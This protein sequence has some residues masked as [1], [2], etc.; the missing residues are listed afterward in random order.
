MTR[1]K[2]HG[3]RPNR[4][5][6]AG[7]RDRRQST[8]SPQPFP[9]PRRARQAE[10]GAS[11][12]CGLPLVQPP[13]RFLPPRRAWDT[14]ETADASPSGSGRGSAFSRGALSAVSTEPTGEFCEAKWL[15]W[16][17]RKSSERAVPRAAAVDKKPVSHCPAGKSGISVQA[18][19]YLGH[20]GFSAPRAGKSGEQQLRRGHRVVVWG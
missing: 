4:T 16:C 19:L 14:D 13:R 8:V 3:C 20:L 18:Y 1:R 9:S 12:V 15:Q 6:A 11:P 17:A 7:R 10:P 2:R 5:P